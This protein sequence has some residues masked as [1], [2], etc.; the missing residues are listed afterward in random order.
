LKNVL[1]EITNVV[2]IHS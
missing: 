1:G 2:S